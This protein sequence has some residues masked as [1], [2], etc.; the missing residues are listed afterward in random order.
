M[1][2]PVLILY[3]ED[4]P[5][6]A[7]LV[8]DQL[9]LAS[10]ACELRIAS[11]RAEYEA[12]LART[13]FDLILSD[14]C[15]PDYDG[16]AALA[17]ARAKQPHVPFILISGTL[18]EEQAVDC[19]LSGA[20][21]YV[22]KQRLNRLVPAMLRALAEAA[23]RQKRRESEARYRALFHGSVDGI[24]IADIE[25][26]TFKY[27]NPALC[28]MLGYTEYELRTMGVPDI[29]PK[30]AIQSVVAEFET[31]ACGDKTLAIGIP[32]LR[33]DGS[34]V[35]A[36][37]NVTRITIDGRLCN[38]G[39]FRDITERK[40]AEEDREKSLQCRQGVNLLHQSLLAPAPLEDKLKTITESVVRLFDAD[41][42]R[43]WLIQPGDL[44]ERGCVHAG[45]KEGPHVCR[46]RDRCLHL[47]ASSG[48]YTHID[49]QAHRRVPFGAYKI[50]RIA[51]GEDHKFLTNDVTNDPLVHNH[52]WARELGLVSFA[53]YQLRIPGAKTLG[54]LALFAKHLMLP[55]EDALLD[56]LSSTLAQA[57]QQAQAEAALRE[58]E[59]QFRAMF[60]V[61]SIGMAQADPQ[62]GQWLRVNQKLCAITGYSADELL[63][64]RVPEITHPDDRQ[65]DLEAFQRVVR[66]EA[67]N[68]RMEKRYV[69]KNRTPVWVNVN[70]TVIR[71]AAGQ[72]IRTIATIEDIAE[73]KAAEERIRAQAELLDLAQDAIAVR[74]MNGGVQYWNKSCERL[75]GWTVAE[76]LGNPATEL[77]EFDPADFD[78]AMRA[79]L[80]EGHWTGEMVVVTKDER[81]IPLMSRWTLVRDG[82]GQPKSVLSI[83]TDMTER[84]KLEAQ[85]LRAQRMESVG[86][87][88]GGIAH[89]L[90]NI[91]APILM[92]T[93]LLREGLPLAEA[94]PLIDTIA[95]SAQRG[96][97]V[98][99]QLLT[100][101]RGT[102][103]QKVALP[104][105]RLIRE[106]ATIVQETFPKS[107][108]LRTEFPK[109]LWTVTA[110][111]TQLH[112][113][114][115][116]LCV[117]ARDAMPK[118][119]TL[120]LAARN[121]TLDDC[122]AGMS[123]EA[124]AGPYVVL[125]VSDTGTGMSR[126]IMDKIFEPFFTT[127]GLET[128]TGLG[129]ATVHGIVQ[130][131]DG[132][133]QVESQ[134]G[135][136]SD[137]RVYLPALPA[138][139]AAL[140]ATPARAL[141]RGHG[142]L[143]LVVD[144]EPNIRDITRKMLEKSGYLVLT[145]NEGTAAIALYAQRQAEIQVVLT[146][147]MMPVMDGP[148]TVRVLRGM[149]PQVKI[150]AASGVA[151]KPKLA[152]IA[153]LPVQAY[154]Q[155]PFASRNLL[156]TLDQVLRGEQT[157]C[158]PGV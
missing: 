68:Y 17:L 147:M 46:D 81:R 140:A 33:K 80:Q 120:T 53:G 128:G 100:F 64:M 54:V 23:E 14:Y 71:D 87:L 114:L 40:W 77:L 89:D 44:C 45:V 55:A 96:A 70:M 2:N 126:E 95:R 73:R 125:E 31:P 143:V 58:S 131:H 24:L 27:A 85:F 50:G 4:N 105:S 97:D 102:D 133:I 130:N 16:L 79:L 66:G 158:Q 99:K 12:A 61:A 122:Y 93:S 48:R 113:V 20:T 101:A 134:A 153:D 51:S 90:N 111:P 43:I 108:A 149:N 157:H 74:D 118:G 62:T 154:L 8:R 10:M 52:E 59:Q 65:K 26:K 30:D 60:E 7:E 6:D 151:S 75:T 29:H 115:L 13:C 18:G 21:D 56:G 109:D 124:K 42:C 138:A 107:I 116:N 39:F 150:I 144:D 146:D 145:A 112:Q 19:L 38:A 86:R 67:P 57:I 47:L 135:R 41:F 15:L 5:R 76:A 37:I 11:G 28:R 84:K 117:N 129:L 139:I 35:Y 136:G 36:D 1:N 82:R 104:P 63:Q 83:N 119:G 88:A 32:C 121:V 152:E 92:G 78:R 91:L 49:G 127:K 155:K 137:F 110:D 106:M 132:F 22:L 9:Q 94:G 34:V 103:G 148:A 69:R 25:T 123:P 72:P 156:V 3:L 141:P 142:Q 98:V